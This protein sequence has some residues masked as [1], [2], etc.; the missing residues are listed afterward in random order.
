[1]AVTFDNLGEASEVERGQWPAERPLGEHFSVTRALP[2]MLELLSELGLPATFFVEGMNAGLYPEPLRSIDGAGHEVALH[3][4]RHESWVDLDRDQERALLERG[5]VALAELGLRPAGFRPPGGEL[6]ASSYQALRACGFTYCSPAGS[7]I[8]VRDGV[9]ILPFRWELI[10]AFHYLPHFASRR[11]AVLGA[12]DALT[13][14]SLRVS[15]ERALHDAVS[16][17]ALLV[18]LFHP[19]LTDTEERLAALRALLSVVR[20][21]VREGAVWCA[22][23]REIA[24]WV[25]GQP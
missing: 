16:R 14:A 12:A 24:A 1:M 21:L 4:W 13:P 6:R 15:V 10:D 2:G 19:F 8:S 20:D 5:V 3:G 25:A 17:G 11:Q 23:M 22:P 7:G 9:A 18:T